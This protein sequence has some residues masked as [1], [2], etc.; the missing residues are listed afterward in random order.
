MFGFSGGREALNPI[1]PK[2]SGR[3]ELRLRALR[4]RS[5]LFYFGGFGGLGFLDFGH[6]KG[7][8]GLGFCN[9]WLGM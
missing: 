1:N 9:L 2:P 6:Y 4:F 5:L 7:F 3:L 8:R